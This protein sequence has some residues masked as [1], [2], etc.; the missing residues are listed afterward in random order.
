MFLSHGLIVRNFISWD[1]WTKGQ[2]LTQNWGL[3]I[4]RMNLF[5][6]SWIVLLLAGCASS[7]TTF[8]AV[9]RAP[10][11]QPSQIH[12]VM[13][14]GL[15]KNQEIRKQVEY[16]FV[17][18]WTD[19]SVECVSSLQTLPSTVP[20]TKSLISSPLIKS[21][22]DAVLVMRV[23]DRKPVAAGE[24]AYS[25][26]AVNAASKVE[27]GNKSWKDTYM[28]PPVHAEPH[29]LVAVETAL[30]EVKSEKRVWYAVSETRVFKDV[31]R[32][33][34]QYVGQILKELKSR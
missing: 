23:I 7:S 8:R 15:F 14:F 25:T 6:R 29:Q 19:R 33:I 26:A 9:E 34:S 12:R 3:I 28:G 24:V 4:P 18:R 1:Y 2:Y 10:G 22:Y 5:K 17:K 21:H 16:E 27:E 30:Y 32:N 13:V 20:L 11:W 31:S